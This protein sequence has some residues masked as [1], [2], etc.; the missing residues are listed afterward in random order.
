MAL[1]NEA[2]SVRD[3]VRDELRRVSSSVDFVA[4]P[5]LARDLDRVLL[6]TQVRET[7]IRLNPDITAAPEKA[8]EVLHELRGIL[9]GAAHTSHPVAANEEFI[10]WL[11]G[12]RSRPLGPEGE[13]VT[14]HL[15]D[16]EDPEANQWTVSTEVTYR[17]GMLEKRFDFVLWCNGFPLIIGEA[18][19]PLRQAITWIDGA[20][21]VH[22]DY[23]KSVPQFFVPNVFNFAT[24]GKDFR[25]GSLGMPIDLW[26]P[27]RE[28]VRTS[29]DQ[30]AQTGLGA[31][32]EAVRG[33]LTPSAV[34]EFLKHFTLY[35]TDRA[36]RK[37]K[38]IARFQQYQA[39]HLIVDRVLAREEKQG[40][41]WHFQGSGKSLLMVFASQKLRSRQELA[42]PT[43]V[44]V[45][46]RIDLNSQIS[47]T[48][49]TSGVNAV[50]TTDSR[51]ELQA[52]LRAEARRV[53][54]TTIHKF[55]EAP[56]VLDERENI[57]VMVDEAHRTQ[58]GDLGQKMRAALPGAFLFGLT[59]TPVN[60]RDRNTFKWFGSAADEGGYLSRYSFQDSIRD[61]A[62]LPLHF[63]PRLTN[64]HIDQ[65]KIDAGFAALADQ[66]GLSEKERAALSQRATSLETLIK[67][68]DRV[69]GI[70]ADI[71]GHFR[72]KVE[73]QGFKA[74]VV[75]YDK[76]A[77]VAY[78]AELDRHLD[79]ETSTIVMSSGP[80]DPDGWAQWSPEAGEL[81]RV[82]ARFNDPAD[83][84]KIIIV[85]AKLLTGF[86]APILYC[87]YLDKPLKEHTLLQA[88]TRAN[89]VYPPAKTHGLIV[90][91]LGI[92]DDVANALE[93]DEKSVRQVVSDINALKSQF[94]PAL[95]RA[96]RFFPGVDRSVGGYQGLLLAQN[97]LADE[98]VRDE[99]GKVYSVV[100]QLWETLSPDPFLEP[101]RTDYRWLTDVYR[102]TAE[103]ES[104]AR[105]I[106]HA[107]GAKTQE[108]INQHV[109]VELPHGQDTIVLDADTIED[110]MTGKRPLDDVDPEDV[111]AEITGRILKHRGN[112]AFVELSKR[113]MQLKQRYSDIQTASLQYLRDLLELAK[114]TLVA[115]KAAEEVPREEQG[116]AALTQL[117]Q[118]SKSEDMPIIVEKVVADID[119]VVRGVRFDGWQDTKAGDQQ[120]R[121]ELRHTLYLKHK[122]RDL[123]IFTQALG[124]ICEYY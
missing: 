105:L 55:G 102:S 12:E 3:Y 108:L 68:P 14:V 93:F 88:I 116:K 41:I 22:D 85:T 51:A 106:W 46:D 28:E 99:F 50:V 111:E 118:A 36:H 83:P 33:L 18:K 120:V 79:E 122:I 38:V 42:N 75:T 4:G 26:G 13:H 24:E 37:I 5:D 112:P 23:E 47:G 54:I 124:Y 96:L 119:D 73:P 29:T 90:D 48:F 27:W 117:F 82:V 77:C 89:R 17:S 32:G 6:E 74:Q 103:S 62:T 58:E 25:Y 11:R 52:L 34:L 31:V 97:A 114:D 98:S 53:I 113:L 86:D 57:I 110:L 43:V 81:E 121:K 100:H 104:S 66:H 39:V 78:K 1:F 8:D 60:K 95:Q 109:T 107:L 20:A 92:F 59:G 2:N 7:L 63:E 49:H 15:I 71:A 19:T 101:F 67:A 64:L 123:D 69:A 84:L 40:L 44:I 91:Y 72:Q 35:A 56:G 16:F 70:C 87:Q 61:G 30:P 10:S 21:Q 94:E 65:A 45:V 9:H 115:E 76:S 80:D